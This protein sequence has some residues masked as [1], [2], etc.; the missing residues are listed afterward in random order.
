MLPRYLTAACWIFLTGSFDALAVK[1]NVIVNW[2]NNKACIVHSP[3]F[4]KPN[5]IK[6]VSSQSKFIANVAGFI[7]GSVC[8]SQ[9]Q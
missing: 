2:Q 8:S 5:L 9:Q 1:K 4:H 3:Y 6:K 7:Q